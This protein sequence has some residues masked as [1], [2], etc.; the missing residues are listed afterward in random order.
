MADNTMNEFSDVDLLIIGANL[1][2]QKNI[3]AK[4]RSF[5]N[6]MSLKIDILIF[7][8]DTFNV[9]L[10]KPNSFAAAVYRQ[11]K[12]IYKKEP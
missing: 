12:L 9:E 7:S 1:N 6:D 4:L 5:A 11:G 10:D 3:I 2:D 8:K